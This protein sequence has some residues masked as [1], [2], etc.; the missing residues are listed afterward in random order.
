MVLASGW[1]P[2]QPL[3]DPF[4]GSGTIA[5]EAA[6]IAAQQAPGAGREFSFQHWP[7]FEPGT[8]ASVRASLNSSSRRATREQ[9]PDATIIACD[10]DRGAI[11]TTIAN[12]E[13][14]GV[15]ARLHT[16][17][18]ALTSTSH[19]D[20]VRDCGAGLVVTNPPYGVRVGSSKGL[21][22]LYATLG[23]IAKGPLAAW[24]L[25]FLAA[26]DT[27]ARATGLAL[28][29]LLR[30]KNGGIDVTLWTRRS[31]IRGSESVDETHLP[32]LGE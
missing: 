19:I 21:R 28:S 16:H 23:N 5:I 10:R 1:E 12:A 6:L 29:P 31:N 14:A 26:D 30:T 17:V 8:W 20:E 3:V 25:A 27:L 4:C 15:A 24:D 9:G 7:S 18:A 22:D 13:R 32:A 2:S 11:E